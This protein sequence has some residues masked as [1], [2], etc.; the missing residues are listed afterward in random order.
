[1]VHALGRIWENLT[2]VNRQRAVWVKFARIVWH[3]SNRTL[4]VTLR[5]PSNERDVS[6]TRRQ[7]ES[8][9]FLNTALQAHERRRSRPEDGV[10]TAGGHEREG[11]S[12]IRIGSEPVNANQ[13]V[14]PS[15]ERSRSAE[16]EHEVETVARVQKLRAAGLSFAAI[17]T[18][19]TIERRA[20]KRGGTWWPA[21]VR[22]IA[23]R[24]TADLAR[25]A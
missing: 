8:P 10:A 11:S 5:D 15:V 17:A 18:T 13:R 1:M 19:L 24:A 14:A 20:S 22:L 12:L 23:M 7:R 4:R 21:T 16:V 2:P 25:A 9:S 6:T 3:E